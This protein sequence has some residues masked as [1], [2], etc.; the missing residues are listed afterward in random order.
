MRSVPMFVAALA[1]SLLAAPALAFDVQNGGA[2]G[3]GG[4]N[5][6]PDADAAAAAGV[7][8]DTDLRTQLGLPGNDKT[9]AGTAT[10]SGLQFGI[11]G[12]ATGSFNT[13]T[14]GYDERP[15]VAPRA[16]PGSN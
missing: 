7:S 13:T 9:T 14:M 6:A 2:S 3:T 15:W 10:K 11:T 5:L 16:R 1:L 8:L 12:G 4:A